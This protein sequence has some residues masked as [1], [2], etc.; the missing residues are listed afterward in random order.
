MGNLI[1]ADFS[2]INSLSGKAVGLWILRSSVPR[3]TKK[4]VIGGNALLDVP[5]S[6]FPSALWARGGHLVARDYGD[7]NG[8]W[9]T[10]LLQ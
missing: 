10:S 9:R 3:T 8:G 4:K 2:I 5:R 6:D 1:S 7:R